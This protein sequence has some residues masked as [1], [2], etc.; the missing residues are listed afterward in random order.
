MILKKVDGWEYKV[1]LITNMGS[2]NPQAA[3]KK[4]VEIAEKH[5]LTGMKIA[6]VTGD[7]IL[8]VNIITSSILGKDLSTLWSKLFHLPCRLKGF[9]SVAPENDVSYLPFL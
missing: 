7:S 4:C 3:A 8:S 9:I 6:C 2:A 1:K 5:G